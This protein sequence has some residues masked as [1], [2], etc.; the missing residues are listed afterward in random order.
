[1]TPVKLIHADN[2]FIPSEVEGIRNVANNMQFVENDYGME[3]PEFN[4]IF[5][6]IEQI[7]TQLVGHPVVPDES[8]SGIF[9]KPM[10]CIHFEAFES[11]EEWCFIIALEKTTFNLYH[12]LQDYGIVN[13]K[14][15]LDGYQ[16][17]Y[18]NMMEW[19]CYT[20]ILLEPNEGVI[21]KPWLFHS[22]QDGLVQYYRLV[23]KK[24][25][26]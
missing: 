24:D 5:P 23:G 16:W 1:M 2:F 20:N 14:T 25:E 18:R 12:H 8:R 4:Y 15:A 13:A 7:F 11:M 17:N 22:L 19:D 26:T 10:N 3:I 9:R 6:D 21:F